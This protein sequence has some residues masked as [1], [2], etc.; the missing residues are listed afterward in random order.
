MA[1]RFQTYKVAA[2]P[3]SAPLESISTTSICCSEV[4]AHGCKGLAVP[5]PVAVVAFLVKTS[6]TLGDA[7]APIAVKFVFPILIIVYLVPLTK[8]PAV[9]NGVIKVCPFFSYCK[10]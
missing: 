6:P 10:K 2:T 1:F 7:E 9:V 4:V 5:V 8:F 3:V